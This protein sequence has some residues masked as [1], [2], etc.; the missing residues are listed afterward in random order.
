MDRK[1]RW[2]LWGIYVVLWTTLLLMPARTIDNLPGV[3]LFEARRY[4]IAKTLHVT[5]YAVMTI[6]C[7]WL[8]VSA[9]WRWLLVFFVMGHATLTEHLQEFVPGR[10]GGLHD[11]GFDNIGIAIGLLLSWNWWVR[12]D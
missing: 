3:D 12:R 9:R 4:L 10:T 2:L 1:A 6:L 5:A 8:H 11:V 7:G